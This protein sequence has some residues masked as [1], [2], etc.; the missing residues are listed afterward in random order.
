MAKCYKCGE[1]TVLYVGGKATCVACDTKGSGK[2]TKTQPS[3][4]TLKPEVNER[5]VPRL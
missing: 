3:A 1:E 4:L 5:R 2:V